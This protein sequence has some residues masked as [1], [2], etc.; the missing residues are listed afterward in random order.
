MVKKVYKNMIKDCLEAFIDIR[1]QNGDCLEDAVYYDGKKE[2]SLLEI[3]RNVKNESKLGKNQINIIYN[4]A[5]YRV[6]VERFNDICANPTGKKI[7]DFPKE[8]KDIVK[9]IKEYENEWTKWGEWRKQTKENYSQ[10]LKTPGKSQE[11][12]KNIF[13]LSINYLYNIVGNK[14][15]PIIHTLPAKNS[16]KG[17]IYEDKR[18]ERMDAMTTR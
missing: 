3:L 5:C 13:M 16:T 14:W 18:R 8:N 6:K 4:Y 9:L 1:K 12:I 11:P 15:H 7:D 2:Y 17:E 10:I